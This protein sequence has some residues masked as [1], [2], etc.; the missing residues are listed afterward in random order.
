MVRMK[1]V[2]AEI[3]TVGDE[4]LYGQIVDTNSH[5]ISKELD[6]IGIK[7]I[8]MTTVP[9]SESE[10]LEA[11]EYAGKRA[12]IV[13][14]TGGLGP[15]SDDLTKP[16][17]A[18]FFNCKLVLNEQ[19]LDDLYRIFDKIGRKMTETN[20]QQ[21]YLPEKC[22]MISNRAGT[23]S[24]MWFQ[25]NS[26]VFVSMPGVPHEMK[27]MM[28]EQVLP[29]LQTVFQTPVIFHKLVKTIGIGE[30]WLAD[31][32]KSWE[33]KLPAYIKLAYLPGLGEVKLRLTA[34]GVDFKELEREVSD[35]LPIL[36]ALAGEFIYG[37]DHDTLPLIIG[38]SL[39]KNKL[40]IA[41]AE[42]CS[43]GAV[44]KALTSTAGSSG[45]FIGSVIAYHNRIK[46][47]ILGVKQETLNSY[48][49]V[50]EETVIEMAENVRMRLSTD[51][52]LATSGIAGPDGGTPDK[53]VGTIWVACADQEK[54]VTKKLSLYK[55]RNINID[56]TTQAVLNLLRQR[57]MEMD[58]EK[59]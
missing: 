17:L 33:D 29:K 9:D 55:D 54:T 1:L 7:T 51:I 48:G 50:S 57:L 23:A 18:K 16:C 13:L 3:L 46:K 2:K 34:T 56:L 31:K 43:G 49:A 35:Q 24:G 28:T 44:A 19:A 8:R 15:T 6:S 53:P 41:T 25:E 39:L 40:T 59:V 5:W 47:D 22:N 21:A 20:R 12:D 38:R 45:Y 14:I 10:I 11:M 37:Y 32:I 58:G 42:S 26:K 52:G 36:R 30:S 27:T 4:I